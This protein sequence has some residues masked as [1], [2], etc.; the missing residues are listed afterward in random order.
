[1]RRLF[2]F[3]AAVLLLTAM[4]C[5]KDSPTSPRVFTNSLTLG[6]GVY[7]I[8]LTGETDTFTITHNQNQDILPTIYWRA[9]SQSK[10]KGAY[11]EMKVERM[12]EAGPEEVYTTRYEMVQL[13]DY[14]AISSYYHM[15]GPGSCRATATL[16][17][18]KRS[19]GVKTFTVK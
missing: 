13:D 6:T 15:Y 11:V 16:G 4:A 7:G 17:L 9:E 1:M 19:I 12:G 10:M 18:E 8:D 5:S 3:F 14:V 2:P